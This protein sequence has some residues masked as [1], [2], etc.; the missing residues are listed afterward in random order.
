MG[1]TSATYTDIA[2]QLREGQECLVWVDGVCHVFYCHAGGLWKLR[3]GTRYP[4]PTPGGVQPVYWQEI[5]TPPGEV[6]D[7]ATDEDWERWEAGQ[8]EARET[9]QT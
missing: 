2:A 9:R 1:T 8:R 7:T 6:M 3:G 4:P 5:E